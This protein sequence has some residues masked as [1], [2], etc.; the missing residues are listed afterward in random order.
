MRFNSVAQWNVIFCTY[1]LSHKVH[2]NLVQF[3]S[4]L[5]TPQPHATGERTRGSE[6]GQVDNEHDDER[7]G[8]R[9][10]SKC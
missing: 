3:R 2:E 1:I 6:S 5:R 7:V 8:N 9:E 10:I 4:D